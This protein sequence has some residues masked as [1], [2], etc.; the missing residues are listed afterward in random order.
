MVARVADDPLALAARRV[1]ED[2]WDH[3]RGYCVPN[4]AVYPH[5][6]LW[7]SCFHAVAWVALGEAGRARRELRRALGHQLPSGFV[8]HMAYAGPPGARRGPLA[9]VSSFTQPPVYAHAATVVAG[10][11]GAGP[12]A[13]VVAR[14]RRGL[15]HLWA[16]RRT[17]EGLLV[18]HHPWETGAD[19]TPRWDD[20]RPAGPWSRT[21][22]TRWEE[23]L[24]DAA[25]Y[26]AEG[27]VVANPRF[28][29]APAAFNAI[30]AHGAAALAGLTGDRTWHHRARALGEAV[31]AHLWDPAEGLWRDLPVAGTGGG[32]SGR[33]PTADALL[34]ALAT[35]DPAKATAALAQAADPERFGAP[36][37]LRYVPRS[38]PAHDPDAYW[39]GP[40][41]PQL[42]YLVWLAARRWG[43]DAT[44]AAVAAMTRR[45]ARA[46]GFAEYWNPD[47]G[48]GRGARPQ[49][50]TALAVALG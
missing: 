39:R 8:P 7:D 26:D 12:G 35:P 15:E 40:A 36:F 27:A 6:W 13:E 9:S 23:G 14:V 30:A 20:W 19:A 3:E 22:A 38:H 4:P 37:G 5:L 17:P 16:T 25:T 29:V 28:G 44:A 45:G 43:D 2:H 32:S 33:V 42:N 1:L 21:R 34:G 31:D 10:A 50:W 18:V 11:G 48:A 49:S 46:S 24:V 47:T 41:W